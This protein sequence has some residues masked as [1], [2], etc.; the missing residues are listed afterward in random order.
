L[1][2]AKDVG[3]WEQIGRDN[4]VQR[5]RRAAWPRWR[6]ELYRHANTAIIAMVWIASVAIGL[7]LLG[8]L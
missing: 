2:G 8:L 6:H 3:H 1:R 4:A 5:E 7:R